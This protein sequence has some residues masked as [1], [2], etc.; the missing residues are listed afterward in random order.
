MLSRVSSWFQRPLGNECTILHNRVASWF[1]C[2]SFESAP[3]HEWHLCVV[4]VVL[5]KAGFKMLQNMMH[6][7]VASLHHTGGLNQ[8]VLGSECSAAWHRGFRAA[9]SNQ[10]TLQNEC[11]ALCSRMASWFQGQDCTAAW[12]PGFSAGRVRLSDC[13]HIVPWHL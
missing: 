7:R 2:L 9:R 5:N 12:H 11:T 3:V 10:R 13:V 8:R 1:Q 6:G 4:L